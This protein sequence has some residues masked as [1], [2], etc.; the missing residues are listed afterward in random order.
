MA[1][2][3]LVLDLLHPIDSVLQFPTIGRVKDQNV[4]LPLWVKED[5]RPKDLTGYDIGFYGRD[6]KG[7]AKIATQDV[8]GPAIQAGRISFTMPAPMFRAAGEYQEAWFRIEKD[9]ELVSSLNVS[10]NVLE[11]NVEFGVDDEPFVSD[12]DKLIA[13]LE[14][15]ANKELGDIRS[16]VNDLLTH[17]ND[18]TDQSLA[19]VKTISER[20]G[21]IQTQID[22]GDVVTR[23]QFNQAVSDQ[24]NTID[25]RFEAIVKTITDGK[26]KGYY[27]SLAALNAALPNGSDGLYAFTSGDSIHLAWWKDSAWYDLGVY[28]GKELSDVEKANLVSLAIQNGNYLH[29][30]DLNDSDNSFGPYRA[31]TAQTKLSRQDDVDGLNWMIAQGT[32]DT[33]TY[34]GFAATYPANSEFSYR[35]YYDAD[36]HFVVRNRTSVKMPITMTTHYCDANGQILA[37]LTN[38]SGQVVDAKADFKYHTKIAKPLNLVTNVNQVD[39]VDVIVYSERPDNVDFGLANMMIENIYFNQKDLLAN[40]YRSNLLNNADLM[41][42]GNSPYVKNSNVNSYQKFNWHGRNWFEVVGTDN[43]TAYKGFKIPY[44]LSGNNDFMKYCDLNLRPLIASTTDT[45]VQATVHYLAS[46]GRIL[47]NKPMGT[48]FSLR[49]NKDTRLKLVVQSPFSQSLDLTQIVSAEVVFMSERTDNVDLLVTDAILAKRDDALIDFSESKSANYVQNPDLVSYSNTPYYGVGLV[50]TEY[51][52]QFNNKNWV[53]ATNSDD[54]V[55][56]KGISTRIDLMNDHD[57][58]RW[59]TMDIATNLYIKQNASVTLLALIK[60][61]SDKVLNTVKL[62]ANQ[63]VTANVEYRLKASL[64]SEQLLPYSSN[65]H[66]VDLLVVAKGITDLV[67]YMTGFT[68]TQRYQQSNLEQLANKSRLPLVFLDGDVTGMSKDKSVAMNFRLKDHSRELT[69]YAKV[70]WQGDS[71]INY[72]KKNYKLKL[73][74]NSGMV[75]KLKIKPF[76]GWKSDSGFNLK[77]NWIDATQMRNLVN[78]QL[79]AEV[80]ANR[81]NVT[82]LLDTDNFG[83]VKGEPVVVILNG[84]IYGLYTF[85]T[86]KSDGLFGMDDDKGNQVVISGEMRGDAISFKSDVAKLDGT[87]FNLEYPDDLTTLTADNVKQLLTWVKNVSDADFVAQQDDH[88]DVN[89]IIDYA[90]F[91]N[92]I[93][94]V[95]SLDKNVLYSTWNG[96]KWSAI[97]YDLDTAWGLKW[98]GAELIDL[99]SNLWN[100]NDN[101]LFVKTLRNN[102]DLLKQRYAELRSTVLSASHIIGIFNERINRVGQ[103]NYELDTTRWPA[104]P[105]KGITDLAQIR[106]AVYQRLAIVDDQLDKL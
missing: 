45:T 60:D 80:T 35:L 90:I 19:Q 54:T 25:G 53:V 82:D 93:L 48:H 62:I 70:G 14:A 26:P 89:S 91:A 17:V 22:A 94:G 104:I 34:K 44:S 81:K 43:T 16:Q 61:A 66:H 103:E 73:Y 28:S 30:A 39:H 55:G 100:M 37:N 85:N 98:D 88:L 24:N 86:K 21:A 31:N 87:D 27:D 58:R 47:I 102:K 2:G 6:A 40:T 10:F 52:P 64:N 20:L 65:S 69:G 96:K 11:N 74:S 13:S 15:S 57:Y 106:K 51:R 12:I 59:F 79:F 56:D 67:M 33:S 76:A 1:N 41:E 99:S 18:M 63:A 32:D 7:V 29:N 72:A 5:S 42:A 92:V 97:A 9:G 95:D 23:Q 83:E 75:N 38:F 78:A 36:V 84:E 49:A 4:S 50:K 68:V 105:S 46:D 3:P 8:V 101:Q 71:S 77:A